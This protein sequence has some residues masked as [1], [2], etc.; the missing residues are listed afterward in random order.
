MSRIRERR[1]VL[2]PEKTER[3][4]PSKPRRCLRTEC[5]ISAIVLGLLAMFVTWGSSSIV[6]AGYELVGTRASLTSV[7]KQNELLR[8]EMARLKSPQRI[9]EIAVK[10]LGMM[11][12]QV[13]YVV[14]R[15]PNLAKATKPEKPGTNETVATRSSLLFG[16]ARAEA[17]N[18]R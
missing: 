11:K 3:C 17:H 14:A 6:K 2:L 8:L 4:S 13:L 7:E 1:E 10:Q 5:V 9:Q 16:N 12:P 15:E 18:A